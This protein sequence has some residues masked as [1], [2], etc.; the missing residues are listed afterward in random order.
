MGSAHETENIALADLEEYADL[1]SFYET[2]ASN[3]GLSLKH[4]NDIDTAR[5]WLNRRQR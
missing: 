5:N 4:F 2:V 1:Q 3:A